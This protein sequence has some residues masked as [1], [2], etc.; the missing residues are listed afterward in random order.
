MMGV[1][2][3]LLWV[4]VT[5]VAL[6]Q[7]TYPTRPVRF[8]VPVPPGGGADMLARTLGQK[9]AEQWGMPV[10]IDNRGG[11]SGT[12]AVDATAKAEIGR[13]HV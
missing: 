5:N 9:L 11:A 2:S 6:A 7:A 12:L 13:A 4:G 8:L 3:L 10:V 1:L